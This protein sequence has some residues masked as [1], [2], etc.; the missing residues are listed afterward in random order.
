MEHVYLCERERGT[1][2]TSHEGTDVDYRSIDDV[3]AWHKDHE[4]LA[5]AARDY[6]RDPG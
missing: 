1:I 6:R 2:R 3:Q 4:R 5:R